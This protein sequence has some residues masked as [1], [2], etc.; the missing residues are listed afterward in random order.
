MVALAGVA[1]LKVFGCPGIKIGPNRVCRLY[2]RCI[3]EVLDLQ[4]LPE[5]NTP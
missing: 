3:G 4:V 1:T 2:P 5:D